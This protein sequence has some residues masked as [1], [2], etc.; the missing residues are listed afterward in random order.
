MEKNLSRGLVYW[1]HLVI[2]YTG[3]FENQTHGNTVA[4]FNVLGFHRHSLVI[5]FYPVQGQ[6]V[7]KNALVCPFHNRHIHQ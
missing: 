5:Y 7:E 1:I 4:G 6:I 3:I 2:P